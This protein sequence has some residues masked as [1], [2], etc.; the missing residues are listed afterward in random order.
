MIVV[1]GPDGSGK[2]QLV[3]SLQLMTGFPLMAKAVSSEM[4][5]TVDV[6]GYIETHLAMGFGKRLY[7]RFALISG[8][9]YGPL[10]GMRPPNH[11]FADEIQSYIWKGR[12]YNRVKPLLIYCLPPADIVRANVFSQQTE[13]S[14]VTEMGVWEQ[15]YWAYR[16]KI[17]ED[18]L[19]NHDNVYRYD[20][21]QDEPHGPYNWLSQKVG[22]THA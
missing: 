12:F 3:R 16:M 21:T 17:D 1:E 8:P 20:Y 22:G 2:T 18:L 6:P 19:I 14:V 9:I 4:K 11:I 5:A 10:C 13:N 15:A 7:D